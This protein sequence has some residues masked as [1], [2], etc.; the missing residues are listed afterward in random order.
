MTTRLLALARRVCGMSLTD[1]VIQPLV[2]DWQREWHDARMRA[3][4]HRLRV[5]VSGGLAFGA[6]LVRCLLGALM[7]PPPRVAA[8]AGLSAF[9]L[10]A[11]AVLVPAAVLGF[12]VGTFVRT[13]ATS[14]ASSALLAVVSLA[15]TAAAMPAAARLRA[16][17]GARRHALQLFL[18]CGLALVLL[19]RWALP[20]MTGPLMV[21]AADART[22]QVIA[23]EQAGRPTYPGT[24]LR[25]ARGQSPAEDLRKWDAYL[26][27]LPRIRTPFGT[28]PTLPADRAALIRPEPVAALAGRML[29][30][31]VLIHLGWNLAGRGRHGGLALAGWWVLVS[32]FL[33]VVDL[34]LSP[35][36]SWLRTASWPVLLP[37]VTFAATSW[38]LSRLT[39]T[40]QR[41][42]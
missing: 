27:A 20:T 41:P 14:G 11:L 12:R 7:Q 16:S 5:L 40:N 34:P 9:L 21:A 32:L 42:A 39:R 22:R 13:G 24:A 31:L 15:V 28:F 18:A 4:M 29:L 6:T 38:G 2:A 23:D 17:G 10:A 19:G 36:G 30:L 26:A 35:P 33:L 8:I 1:R 37:I 25:R 3:G